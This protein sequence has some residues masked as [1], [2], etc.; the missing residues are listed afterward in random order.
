MT[1][2]ATLLPWSAIPSNEAILARGGVCPATAAANAAS[3]RPTELVP[4][5]TR[6]NR[7]NLAICSAVLLIIVVGVGLVQYA[8]TLFKLPGSTETHAAMSISGSELPSK[9]TAAPAGYPPTTAVTNSNGAGEPFI[10]AV[11]NPRAVGSGP[12]A[13]QTTSVTSAIAS[14]E[15]RKLTAASAPSA[16][17]VSR[18]PPA[19]PGDSAL[20]ARALSAPGLDRVPPPR[21]P[22]AQRSVTGTATV[23]TGVRARRVEPSSSEWA[24]VGRTSSILIIK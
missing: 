2:S 12:A 19:R 5:P 24:D 22:E 11:S 14:G 23:D 9:A 21:P 8:P 17:A 20:T 16:K 6:L 4:P 10:A 1:F 15:K 13:T 7:L 18:T 3:D